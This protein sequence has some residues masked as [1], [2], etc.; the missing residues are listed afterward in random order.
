MPG[1][2]EHFLEY[3]EEPFD[4]IV[5]LGVTEHLPD[6]AATLA[7]YEQLLK[8]GGRGSDACA[9]RTSSHF[10]RS[11]SRTYGQAM[12]LRFNSRT[13]C[14]PSQDPFELMSVRTTAVTIC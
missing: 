3:V 13:I 6:Y 4:A 14:A 2:A 8:P 7:R 12:P 1:G 9:S 5:N 10:L 11:F